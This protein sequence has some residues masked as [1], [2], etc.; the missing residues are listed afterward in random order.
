MRLRTMLSIAATIALSVGMAP[1]HAEDNIGFPE[2]D[3]HEAYNDGEIGF[4]ELAWAV[5]PAARTSHNHRPVDAACHFATRPQVNSSATDI[6]VVAVAKS[7][8]FRKSDGTLVQPASTGVVCVLKNR[9]GTEIARLGQAVAGNVGHHEDTFDNVAWDAPIKVCAY[10]VVHWSDL[11]YQQ[12][13]E[14][15]NRFCD[16]R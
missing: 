4:V 9:H 16:V 5:D 6:A 13:P 8:A 11:V 10:P 15:S 3:V 2:P 12:E 7:Y 14:T 1:A